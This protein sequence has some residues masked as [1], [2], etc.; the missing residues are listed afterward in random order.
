MV[1]IKISKK[2][3]EK[4]LKDQFGVKGLNWNKDGSCEIEKDLEDIE[5]KE[6]PSNPI[7]VPIYIE[8]PV[9]I[10]SRRPWYPYWSYS[11]KTQSITYSGG[12][13]NANTKT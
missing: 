8:R 10:P 4:F 12:S 13:T 6:I 3:I 7:T 1:K 2:E 11:N 9:T 5:K